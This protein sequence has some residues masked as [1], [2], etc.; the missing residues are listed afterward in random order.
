M[1][2]YLE[3]KSF[4]VVKSN[5]VIRKEGKYDIVAVCAFMEKQVYFVVQY[6]VLVN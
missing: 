2:D 6:V 5:N 4:L 3:R 1:R